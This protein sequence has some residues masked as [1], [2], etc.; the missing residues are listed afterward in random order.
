MKLPNFEY[1]V[2]EARKM[3]HYL[4][5]ED[6][7]G[8]KAAF[9]I[10]FGFSLE[11]WEDLQTM[12]LNHASTH[13]VARMVPNKHGMKYIIEGELQTP[14]RRNPQIRSVW[15]IEHEQDAARFVTA[16]ALEGDSDD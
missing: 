9:F 14:D 8:G 12:L 6:N 2:V 13:E 7:S 15:I 4:L 1:A 11:Q 16:Y 5:S 3:T 10:S